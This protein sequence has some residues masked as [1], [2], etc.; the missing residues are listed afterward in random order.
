MG[1]GG[2]S[3]K[4][5]RGGGARA[6]AVALLAG[7]LALAGCGAGGS[8][9]DSG[10]GAAGG[11]ARPG[12]A[13]A[14]DSGADVA[15]DGEGA[16]R[17][18][19]QEGGRAKRPP[20]DFRPEGPHVIR[21]VTLTVRVKDV[22]KALGRARAAAEDADGLVGD[23]TTDRDGRGRERSRVVLRVPQERYERVLA[24]LEGTG[25]LVERSA[26]A[27]DVTEEVVD[28]ESRIKTQRA[29]VA[30]VRVLM[31]KATKISDIVSLEGELSTRQADLEAL[32]ARQASLKDRTALATI[33]L[34]LTESPSG[35]GGGGRDE[36]T[37]VDAA[38]G[39]WDAFVTM[40]RWVSVALGAALPFVA[41]AAVL[42][43][44][45]LRWGR[46]RRPGAGGAAPVPAPPQRAPQASETPAAPHTPDGD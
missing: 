26:K 8:D 20:K 32:L 25:R 42:G 1:T 27:E 17:E 4:A 34:T 28:V 22:P 24:D 13:A 9:D 39:G 41:G 14:G 33:T 35:G 43:F 21:T 46:T 18:G 12:R 10:K 30:R 40:L 3:R 38:S 37:F 23:E 36:P 7:A 31:D 11:E 19:G 15:G 45:W 6:L 16:A 2:A 5:A 29:S 44:A